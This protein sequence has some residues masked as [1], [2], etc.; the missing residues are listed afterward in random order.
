M[1][2]F[3]DEV[4]S[5]IIAA[6]FAIESAKNALETQKLPQAEIAAKASELLTE[7]VEKLVDVLEAKRDADE[8]AS[9]D[10]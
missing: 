9:Q 7:A 4:S 10:S 6:L 8:R 3:H 2:R 1:Q 5:P